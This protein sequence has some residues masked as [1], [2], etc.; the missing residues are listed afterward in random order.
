M[1]AKKQSLARAAGGL[2]QVLAGDAAGQ[3]QAWVRRVDQA[4]ET[5]EQAVRH[6]R[7]TLSDAEG[8]VVDVDSSLNPSPGVARRADGLR[9]ELD[10]LVNQATMLRGK[11]KSIHP[12]TEATDSTNAAGALPVAPEVGDATDFSVFCERA[13]QLLEGLGR[14]DEE[15]AALIED[16]VT[17]DLGAGD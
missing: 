4:L 5:V 13:E 15:E 6:H 1:A 10:A 7:A 17:M 2:K 16:S 9:Q 8:R 12:P 3:G 14:Y 11:L